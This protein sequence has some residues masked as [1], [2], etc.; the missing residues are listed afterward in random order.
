MSYN[1]IS[2]TKAD[3]DVLLAQLDPNVPI[4]EQMDLLRYDFRWEVPLANIE[5]G[6]LLGHGAFGKGEAAL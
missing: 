5:F 6:A 1:L 3:N 4:H 2:S